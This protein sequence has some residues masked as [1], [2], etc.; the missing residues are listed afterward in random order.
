MTKID[1]RRELRHL[2]AAST[3]EVVEVRVPALRFLMVDGRGDPNTEPAYAEAVEAL[4]S[5]S[6]AAKFMLKKAGGPDYAVMPL[7]GLWWVD[8]HAVFAADDRARWR[9]RM[10]VL[11]PDFVGDALLEAAIAQVRAKKA[12]P[13]LDRLRLEAFTEGRCAQVLHVGPF[14]AEGPTIARVHDFIAGRGR[15]AGRHHEIYLSDVRRAD[16]AKWRT[17]IR[18]PMA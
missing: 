10:M 16:P 14:S 5:V 1:L 18:Q 8:D 15:L 7:E 9:W 11:Q 3:K 6:Y 13:G 4:F 17:I 12:L 2:Y